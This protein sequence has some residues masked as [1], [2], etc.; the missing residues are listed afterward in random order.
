M[1][2]SNKWMREEAESLI[3]ELLDAAKRDGAQ[4]VKDVD[5]TFTISFQAG[6]KEGAVKF[7]ASGGPDRS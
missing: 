4:I 3:G 5:G 2:R 7:L 6:G 1:R